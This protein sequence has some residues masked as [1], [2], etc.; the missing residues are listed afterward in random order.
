MPLPLLVVLVAGMLTAATTV[1]A[2]ALAGDVVAVVVCRPT[3]SSR[4][5]NKSMIAVYLY[6]RAHERGVDPNLFGQ[7]ALAPLFNKRR[8]VST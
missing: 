6:A 5:D 1:F 2:A 7:S 8:T 3:A 4:A